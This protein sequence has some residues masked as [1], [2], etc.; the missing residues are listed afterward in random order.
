MK[1]KIYTKEGAQKGEIELADAVFNVEPKQQLLHQVVT[2]Y[3]A[4]QRQG[5][6]KAKGRSEVSGGGKKPWRQKGTGHARAGS[7]TS[8]V[9]VRGGKAFGPVPRDYTQAIPKKMRHLA[10]RSALS[11]RARGERVKVLEALGIEA[12]KTKV[13]A[14]LMKKLEVTGKR[15]LLVIDDGQRNTYLSA[16]NIRD[17]SV[18]PVSQINAYD[19]VSCDNLVFGSEELLKKVEEAVSK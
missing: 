19:V 4:N 18:K 3:L 7:N 13:I 2:S 8:P 10:L 5:T 6:A 1:A 16:R 12:P 14:E 11:E 17:L 9:W 15:T